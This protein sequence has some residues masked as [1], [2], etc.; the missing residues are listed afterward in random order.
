MSDV[1]LRATRQLTG[2]KRVTA[3]VRPWRLAYLVDPTN[4]DQ[5]VAAID[6]CCLLWG[7]PYNVLIP[8]RSNGEPE[9]FW[10]TLLEQHDP[11][12]VIDLV[13]ADPA[14]LDYQQSLRQRRTSA[15]TRSTETMLLPGTILPSIL[16]REMD[17]DRWKHTFYI[18]NLHPLVGHSLA[19]PLA[20]RLGHLERRPM[21]HHNLRRPSY[22]EHRLEDVAQL[23]V[24]DPTSIPNDVLVQLITEYP[25]PVSTPERPGYI[26]PPSFRVIDIAHNFQAS[27][28][29]NLPTGPMSDDEHKYGDR[30]EHQMVVIGAADSVPDLC[31]AWNLRALRPASSEPIFVNRDWLADAAVQQR[32][33][34]AR[35]RN[36][37]G[38]AGNIHPGEEWLGF[39][40]TSIAN[41]DLAKLAASVPHAVAH[42]PTTLSDLLPD[43]V[44]IGQSR[45][46]TAIF[47]DSIAD[48]A[49][50]DLTELG[51]FGQFETL[52]VTVS[53]PEWQLP[54]MP[55]PNF[56]SSND[57]V[58][59]ARDG[60]VGKLRFIDGSIPELVTVNARNGQE[61]L[62]TLAATVGFAAT[63]SDK[64]R[65]AI[66]VLELF[67]STQ[68]LWLLASSQV[69][70]LLEK[71]A[72]G[73]VPRQA[74]QSA[75]RRYLEEIPS[76]ETV[77]SVHAALEQRLA[78]DGQFDRQHFAGNR[79]RSLLGVKRE[80]ADWI[81]N[82]LVQ[83]GILFRGY[84]LRCPTCGLRRWQPI[85]HMA[86]TYTCDGCL[87]T[88]P[89]PLSNND[90]LSWRYRLNELVG[91]AVDQGVLPHLLAMRHLVT[92][93]QS[94]RSTLL[95]LLPGVDFAGVDHQEGTEYS[96]NEVDLVAILAGRILVGECKRTGAELSIDD[97]QKT[98]RLAERFEHP[99]VVFATPTSFEQATKA[100]TEI[101]TRRGDIQVQIWEAPDM[102]DPRP[103]THMTQADPIE[104]LTN[105]VAWL[106]KR[107]LAQQGTI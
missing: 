92:Q 50:P 83:R 23:N 7:G 28:S 71:A 77:D 78:A 2:A 72:T 47:L 14:F 85:D 79:L 13:G 64:G 56:G 87:I 30:Y 91:Q 36:M 48:V 22:L 43:Q 32:L 102:L 8:C 17:H 80:D 93:H 12:E 39:V 33:E 105:I 4:P 19:L 73:I 3:T 89:T 100:M 37:R 10:R 11:D 74:T 20:Y 96:R 69:Y 25:L 76:S 29:R 103:H 90:S 66:A 99:L 101:Q 51:H 61:A 40:S 15:W 45:H 55:K 68:A 31:L 62:D 24:V 58:R 44:T 46:S 1:L 86:A 6:A 107:S 97:V 54:P 34:V 18:L 70:G 106:R 41:D 59:V 52:G 57:I 94:S 67:G 95:G 63:V 21:D 26:G 81:L 5:A 60:L 49:L 38:P 42:S 104:Y 88:I 82:F 75:L 16:R 27:V 9:G 98:M 65:L 35:G 53:I 84:A